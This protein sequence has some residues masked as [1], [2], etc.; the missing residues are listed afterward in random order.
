MSKYIKQMEMD[1][2]KKTFQ[3]VRDL[4]VLNVVG[5]NAVA[6]NQI[7]HGLR[8]KGIRLKVV[9]NS[10]ARR[11]FD[12]LGL[13]LEKAWEGPTTVA[14]GG[15][16]IAGLSKEIDGI[17]KKH[18]K[19]IKVKSAVADGQEIGFDLAL[20]MPTREEAIAQV[21]SLMLSPARNLAA[22]LLG[23]ASQLASQLKTLGDKK[24]EM[25]APAA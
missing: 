19:S 14:W 23:P 11:V 3:G 25:A 8:K 5:L 9:K 1:S 2:L 10:L 15:S 7:R 13:R 16:S 6:D 22:A 20:T 4:V 24:E 17:R 12:D 18:D 21:V